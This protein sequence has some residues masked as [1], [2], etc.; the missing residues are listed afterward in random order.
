MASVKITQNS[1]FAKP[2]QR[3]HLAP[4]ASLRPGGTIYNRYNGQVPQHMLDNMNATLN[5]PHDSGQLSLG[6]PL[7]GTAGMQQGGTA[8]MQSVAPGGPTGMPQQNPVS[9][10]SQAPSAPTGMP[11]Q[12]AQPQAPSQGQGYTYA[13]IG[14]EGFPSQG[15]EYLYAG[16]GEEG[17]SVFK[18]PATGE[19]FRYPGSQGEGL[20]PGQSAGLPQPQT[21]QTG[22]IGSEQALKQGLGAAGQILDQSQ[23]QGRGDIN[24]ASQGANSTL[25]PYYQPGQQSNQYQAALSGALGGQS[26]QQAMDRFM[27][28]PGQQYLLDESERSITRNAAATGG[29]GGANVQRALQQNAVGLAAQDFDNAFNRL[30]TVSDRGLAAG[31]QMAGNQMATGQ[32]L[33]GLGQDYGRMGADLAYGTGQGLAQGRT[34]AGDQ[35]AGNIQGTSF[36]LADTMRGTGS[37]QSNVI[38]QGGSNLAQLLA[39]AGKDTF[40]AESN[41]AQILAQISQNVGANLAGQGLGGTNNVAG[42]GDD[43]LSL[44]G[45]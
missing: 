6:S 40:N 35:I 1:T 2:G 12:S 21:P 30:G 37:E 39:G 29:L 32:A 14:R 10:Q 31:G 13:G 44:I 36:N 22:L 7:A 43:I 45:M 16:I 23:A 38:G 3:S 4:F 15:Q 18:D 26:Q 9:I 11:Q 25:N 42:V 41:L 8:G 5:G 24:S 33:A 17:K 34:R 28:S 19:V 20:T 27:G